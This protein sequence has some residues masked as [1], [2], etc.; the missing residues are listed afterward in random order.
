LEEHR[1]R[2]ALNRINRQKTVVRF[3]PKPTP[4]S[5][6]I[7]VDRLREQMSNETLEARIERMLKQAVS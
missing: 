2:A 3:P 4:F 6:P 7:M 5:F 1:L